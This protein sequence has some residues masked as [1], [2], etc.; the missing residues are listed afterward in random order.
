MRIAILRRAYKASWSMDVYADRLISGLKQVRPDWKI[1]ECAPTLNSN[2]LNKTFWIKGIQKYYERYWRYPSS[3]LKLN[4]DIFHI[5]DHSDGYLSIWLKHRKKTNIVTCHDLVNLIKPETFVGRARLPLISMLAW[6]IGVKGMQQADRVIAV[7]SHTKNDTVEHLD[8][9]D[10]KITV[11][12]NAVDRVFRRLPNSEIQK[13]RQQQG[14]KP[15]T[16]CL[17]NVGSNNVRKNISTILEVVAIL[18]QRGL[19]VHFWKVGG[20]FS[21]E[22]KNFIC[23]RGLDGY[24]SYLG[25]PDENTLIDI[26]NAAD[27]LLAPST[28]EGFGLTIL[29]AMACGTAVITS[30]V[31][32]MPEVAGDAGIL[33]SPMDA[34]AISDQVQQLYSNPAYRQEIVKKGLA[35]AK[36]FTWEQTAEQVAR[37]YEQVLS[38]GK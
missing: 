5:I 27:C 3:L 28:Y 33:V 35:R 25:Q 24:I 30:N 34:E 10:R 1:V 9:C 6:R 37:V 15:N 21:H 12:P 18:Q 22:Q 16:F 14:L 20:D 26:Y 11:I 2:C 13:F 19:P 8:I 32:S 29:E 4:A 7:S 23:D 38:Q 36:Q 31:T 17:L